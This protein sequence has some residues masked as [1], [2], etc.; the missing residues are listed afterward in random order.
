MWPGAGIRSG[1]E[2]RSY[3]RHTVSSYYHRA[4]TCRMGADADAVVDLELRVRGVTGLR[5]ADAPVFPVIPNAHPN[6]TVLAAEKAAD[7]IRR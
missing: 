5:V 1:V 6:A 7:L 3:I 4:G 2:L